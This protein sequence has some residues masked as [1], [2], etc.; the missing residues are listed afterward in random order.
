[1]G[2]DYSSYARLAGSA[3]KPPNISSLRGC[4]FRGGRRGIA[5]APMGPAT[6]SQGLPAAC[7]QKLAFG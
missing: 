4:R 2:F 3:S 5:L 1:M 7:L 6:T